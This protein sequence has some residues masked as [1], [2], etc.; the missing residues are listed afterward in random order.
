L[1]TEEQLGELSA[2]QRRTEERVEELSAAQRRTEERVEELVAAQRRTEETVEGLARGLHSLRR[3]VGQLTQLIG[4]TVEQDG[5]AMV[6]YALEKRGLTLVRDP[7][8]VE[9]NGELDVVAVA[10]GD[11]AGDLGILVESK[12]RLRPQDVR[13]FAANCDR[14]AA[15]AGLARPLLA[16]VYGL[17]VYGGVPEAAQEL[18]IG[19]LDFRGERVPAPTRV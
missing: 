12:V 6:R 13:R 5:A 18:G 15:D 17:R 11:P 3:E 9:V 7:E 4:G 10:R 1:R 8:P 2:A 19:V 16:Y 14:Q